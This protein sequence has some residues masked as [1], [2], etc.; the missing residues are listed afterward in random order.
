MITPEITITDTPIG[1]M[2]DRAIDSLAPHF[3]INLHDDGL[4]D[5]ISLPEVRIGKPSCGEHYIWLPSNTND[6]TSRGLYIV[7]HEVGHWYH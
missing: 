6:K 1:R 7:G 2:V 5:K 3:G 4:W